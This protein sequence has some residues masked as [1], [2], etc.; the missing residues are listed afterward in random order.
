MAKFIMVQQFRCF[1]K[2]WKIPKGKQRQGFWKKQGCDPVTNVVD[3]V[4]TPEIAE[5]EP[6]DS[7]TMVQVQQ[8]ERQT[9]LAKGIPLAVLRSNRVSFAPDVSAATVYREFNFDISGS[10]QFP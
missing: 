1:W 9:A 10:D 8:M 7:L 3:K 6:L 4:I 2:R 5:S